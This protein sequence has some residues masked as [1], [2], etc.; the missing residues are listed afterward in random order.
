MHVMHVCGV[1]VC[2]YVC[3]YV[4]CVCMYVRGVCMHVM[5]VCVLGGPSL[6][7]HLMGFEGAGGVE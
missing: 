2:V 7:R 1:C 3:M 4:V 5:Y 6:P